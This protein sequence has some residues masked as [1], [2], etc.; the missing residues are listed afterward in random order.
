MPARLTREQQRPEALVF[1]HSSWQP[2]RRTT[3]AGV[4][5]VGA[6]RLELARITQRPREVPA[7]ATQEE[8]HASRFLGALGG[9]RVD[10]V[11]R[12]A[13]RA[14]DLDAGRERNGHC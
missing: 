9:G 14:A 4:L 5:D 13:V 2:A 3:E 6:A 12:I 11:P 10:A 7:T 1:D 8:H